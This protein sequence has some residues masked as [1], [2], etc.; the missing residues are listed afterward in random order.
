MQTPIPQWDVFKQS[1]DYLLGADSL[2]RDVRACTDISDIDLNDPTTPYILAALRCSSVEDIH[3]L[4]TVKGEKFR[5]KPAIMTA[6]QAKDENQ[7]PIG[8]PKEVMYPIQPIFFKRLPTRGQKIAMVTGSYSLRERVLQETILYANHPEVDG[9]CRE[10]LNK[11]RQRYA[12][13]SAK[14]MQH[15]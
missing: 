9:P 2:L 10:E 14:W 15:S 8:E 1:E 13:L 11:I 7:Q 12:E 5:I 3:C 6:V 4:L